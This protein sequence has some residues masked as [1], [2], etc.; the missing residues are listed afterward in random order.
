MIPQLAQLLDVC[1]ATMSGIVERLENQHMVK[2]VPD[3]HDQRVRR[4]LATS[5]GRETI[6]KLLSSHQE[7]E[8]AQLDKLAVA[9]LAALV[10][11]VRAVAKVMQRSQ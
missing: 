9:D 4:V 7:L 1:L 3:P 6:R 11:G 10:Q 2:R 5:L 8:Y